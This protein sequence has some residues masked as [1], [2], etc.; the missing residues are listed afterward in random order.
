M[1]EIDF[2]AWVD[3]R[4]KSFLDQDF[5]AHLELVQVPFAIATRTAVLVVPDL[6]ELRIGFDS[7]SD[8]LRSQKATDMI[9]TARQVDSIHD[10]MISGTFDTE[11]LRDAVRVCDPYRS[12]ATLRCIDGKWKAISIANG[13]T[14]ST[15]PFVLPNV[16]RDSGGQELI[17]TGDKGPEGENNG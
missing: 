1:R 4:S 6:D 12:T 17:W 2:Q 15:W 11:I 16:D 14:N 3:A 5:D 9:C 8:M 13:L 7:W 10:D